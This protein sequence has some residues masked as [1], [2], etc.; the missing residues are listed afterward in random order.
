MLRV[1]RHGL[2]RSINGNLEHIHIA[3]AQNRFYDKAMVAGDCS[4]HQA[5]FCDLVLQT[6]QC[7]WSTAITSTPAATARLS[8]RP[9]VRRL[10]LQL[11]ICTRQSTGS[12]HRQSSSRASA[13]PVHS[14][15]KDSIR[16]PADPIQPLH[17]HGP[18]ISLL[19]IEA[20]PCSSDAG[21]FRLK[22]R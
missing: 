7:G 15:R 21:R 4:A 6:R 5:H 14:F 16:E 19:L 22:S 8:N 13:R 12:Y 9:T 2:H 11:L 1:C 10:L 18:Q 20:S 3:E 17:R